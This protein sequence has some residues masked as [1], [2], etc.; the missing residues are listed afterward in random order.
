MACKLVALGGE[1]L[2]NSLSKGVLDEDVEGK[3]GGVDS[4]GRCR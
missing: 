3:G 2:I 4:R 1:L